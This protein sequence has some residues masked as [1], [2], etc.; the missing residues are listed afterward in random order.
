MRSLAKSR[1]LHM[2]TVGT[3]EP[4]VEALVK[5]AGRVVPLNGISTRVVA[6]SITSNDFAMTSS[7][8][9]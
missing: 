3:G 5:Y 4:S 1:P 7:R 9:R 6:G 2:I 8:W